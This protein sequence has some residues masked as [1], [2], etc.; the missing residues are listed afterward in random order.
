MK[1]SMAQS[2]YGWPTIKGN[3]D[4]HAKWTPSISAREYVI[5]TVPSHVAQ[6]VIQCD[7]PECTCQILP[8]DDGAYQ[9][10]LSKGAHIIL[11]LR[12][13]G[14]G[15]RHDMSICVDSKGKLCVERMPLN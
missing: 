13:K 14:C 12:K 11:P 8:D 2:L 1:G 10:V 9:I 15:G 4:Q 3:V 7:C 6:V 5:H